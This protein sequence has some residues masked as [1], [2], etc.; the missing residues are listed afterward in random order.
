LARVF[1]T[2][3]ADGLG[4]MAAEHLVEQ[5][6]LVVLH[7]RSAKRADDVR[8][9]LDGAEAIAVGDFSSIAETRSV[10]DQV[11]KL[12]VFDAVIHNAGIG[13]RESALTKTLRRAAALRRQHARSLHSHVSHHDADPTRVP[14]LRNALWSRLSPRRYSLET[15]SV[16]WLASLRR[17]P[18]SGLSAD[19]CGRSPIPRREI[20][21]RR[22]WMG[23]DQ[24]GRRRGPR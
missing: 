16:E 9:E 14:L 8:A 11:N 22:A 21:C 4:K 19:I 18:V 3:S 2:G 15:A 10:A 6:H 13:Y 20:E 24:D 7:A 12:G 23:S 5:G 1:I 17:D